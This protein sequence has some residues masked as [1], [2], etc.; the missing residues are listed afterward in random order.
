MF[1]PFS[2]RIMPATVLLWAVSGATIGAARSG[3]VLAAPTSSRES[4]LVIYEEGSTVVVSLGGT[5]RLPGG[6]GQAEVR[7][8]PGVTEID[9]TLQDMKP[10]TL[11]GGDFVT[12]VLWTVSPEGLAINTGEFV[13]DGSRG[14]LR[15]SSPLDMFGLFVTAEPHY[16]V[17]TPSRFVVLDNTGVRVSRGQATTRPVRYGGF[18]G[19]YVFERESLLREQAARGRMRTELPQARVAVALAE[20]A[21]G[22]RFAPGELRR[23]AD[24]LAKAESA[25]GRGADEEEVAILA[26]EAVRLA[27]AAQQAATAAGR[28]AALDEERRVAQVEIDALTAARTAADAAAARLEELRAQANAEAQEARAAAVRFAQLSTESRT[29][30]ERD[31]LAAEEARQ[32]RQQA[33]SAQAA[34]E[35]AAQQARI[36]QASARAQAEESRRAAAQLAELRALAE[37]DAAQSR[38]EAEDARARMQYALGLV[39]ET[40]ASARGVIVSLPDILFDTGQ[41][42]LRPQAREVLSRIAGV[43]LVAPDYELTIEGHTDS[44]GTDDYNQDLSERRSGSVRA[45]LGEARVSPELMRAV[46]FGKA[47][48]IASNDTAEGRQANRRVEIVIGTTQQGATGTN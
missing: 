1:R 8:R 36:E 12:Y 16:L 11:F 40:S 47:R 7:R 31:R 37:R 6:R 25:A 33:L 9:V 21:G 5:L 24:A 32:A 43:L 4:L 20:R 38:Q 39:A 15:V 10:A 2:F 34:A 26:H 28:Q 17:T 18:D 19:V 44:V 42:T 35:A 48:P 3:D 13:L 23:A 14:R 46:G 29:Q 27:V 30:A 41:A 22:T 45:Y